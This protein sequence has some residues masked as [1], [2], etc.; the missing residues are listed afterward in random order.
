MDILTAKIQ[1]IVK[2]SLCYEC[3]GVV[4]EHLKRRNPFKH[5][6][7]KI[8]VHPGCAFEEY[9]S[10][11]GYDNS[12]LVDV[13]VNA[14]FPGSST[15]HVL[16]ELLRVIPNALIPRVDELIWIATMFSREQLTFDEYVIWIERICNT[17]ISD[18]S[19]YLERTLYLISPT[20][21]WR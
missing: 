17:T 20:K 1:E 5:H 15:D 14:V 10:Y 12:T 6:P 13:W 2:G 18:P 21:V 3:C 4:P 19:I 9:S 7:G 16:S 8:I 11:I